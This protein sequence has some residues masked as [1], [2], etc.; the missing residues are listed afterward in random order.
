MALDAEED[1]FELRDFTE[2]RE[3]AEAL[4]LLLRAPL[5]WDLNELA[6]EFRDAAEVDLFRWSDRLFLPAL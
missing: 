2:A 3:L 4:L 6:L 5:D 1:R